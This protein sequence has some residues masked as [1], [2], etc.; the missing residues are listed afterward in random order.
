MKTN[1]GTAERIMDAAQQMVQ[2][3]GYN[4]F[5]Y[6]D[7]STR[8]GIRKASIHYYFPSKKDLG[9]ELAAR[10][11]ADFHSRLHRIDGRKRDSRSKLKAYAQLYL[12]SLR[13]DD[14]MCLC[15]M[16]ASDIDTL[17]EEVRREVIGFF[18]DNEAWL[19]KVLG[20]GRKA[21]TLDFSG[22]AEN[23]AQLLLAGFQGA[24]LVAR[25][26]GD[27]MRFRTIARKLLTRLGIKQQPA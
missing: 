26:Y 5:S 19:A 11:R 3:R 24:M 9:K 18:S 2:T 15:G 23:E 20:E 12:D 7:I 10:Y 4:A 1:R 25:S 17:P 22:P 21:G 13:D 16:L 14:R 6:A 27:G 8:V